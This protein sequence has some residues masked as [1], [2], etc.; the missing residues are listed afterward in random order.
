MT[1]LVLILVLA[2]C[3]QME[4]FT[5]FQKG[6]RCKYKFLKLD[7]ASCPLV[8]AGRI[9]S[10]R[11]N[12][13][14]V[15]VRV[16][17]LCLLPL[18]LLLTEDAY[19]FS[20]RMVFSDSVQIASANVYLNDITAAIQGSNV[21]KKKA[22]SIVV[23][24]APAAGKVK[25]VRKSQ[26]LRALSRHNINAT[27]TEL[28]IP[29]EIRVSRK[30]VI[31]GHKEIEKI[32]RDVLL[33]K[34]FIDRGN[35]VFTLSGIQKDVTLPT[36]DITTIVKV[37]GRIKALNTFWVSFYV[38]GR[39]KRRVW[40]K[41]EIKRNMEVLAA[42]RHISANEVITKADLVYMKRNIL[43]LKGDY[44][45][46]E[47]AVI[48]KRAARNIPAGSIIKKNSIG[49]VAAVKAGDIV[50]ILA[51]M[52]NLTLNVSGRVISPEGSVGDTVTVMN[53]DSREKLRAVVLN[54]KAVNVEVY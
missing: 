50:T 30:S 41:G 8:S 3:R 24:T 13:Q 48:G 33:K 17:A 38:D 1:W 10:G 52:K 18:T 7:W 12:C 54:N 25:V 11:I 45:T 15:G 20:P 16:A 44:I 36:G 39:L 46:N 28:V 22:D 29:D 27:N 34:N 49:I 4:Y 19:A 37:P 51:R 6:G 32:I 47:R 42:G 40:A 21:L 9:L 43:A 26:V 23:T 35:T 14:W 2:H 5:F 53:I 31:Y